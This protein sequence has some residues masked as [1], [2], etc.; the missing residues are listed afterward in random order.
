M[1]K[2]SY[3]MTQFDITL[4][5]L[6]EPNFLFSLKAVISLA[7]VPRAFLILIDKA[8]K[9]YEFSISISYGFYRFA[10]FE[11]LAL[12]MYFKRVVKS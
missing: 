3:D 10:K 12:Y 7:A 5:Q 8:E 4:I 9:Y 2:A 6:F 11:S 1:L